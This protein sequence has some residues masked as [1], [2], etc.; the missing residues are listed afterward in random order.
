MI[1]YKIYFSVAGGST[2]VGGGVGVT[3]AGVGATG[4]AISTG[5]DDGTIR[6]GGT[7]ARGGFC[8]FCFKV[9]K[10]LTN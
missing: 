8:I 3:E 5:C 4:F 6:L 7:A 9:C 1:T 2:G 10:I